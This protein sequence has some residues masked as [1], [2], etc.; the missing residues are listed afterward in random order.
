MSRL[1]IWMIATGWALLAGAAGSAQAQA[2]W[3]TRPIVYVVP[4]AVGGNTDTLARL[5]S[6]KLAASLGQPIVIENK[7]GAGGNIGSD[8]VAKAKPDGYTILGGTISSHAINA[9]VYPN[10]PYDPVKSFE[11]VILLGSNPL[12]FAVNASTPYKSLKEVLDAAK[13]KPGELAFASPGPGTSPHL[14]GELLKTLTRVD[15]THVPYKGSGPALSDVIGGQVPI[16]IDTTIVLGA[17]IKAGKL[18]PLAV[19]YPKRLGTLPDVPTAAEAGVPGWEVVSWQAVFA[20]AGTPKP[21]VQRLNTEI[22]RTMKM[23]DVQARLVDLGVEVG[24]GPPE[25]LAEFQ[26]AEIAKWATVVKTAGV[27]PE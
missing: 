21:I 11:P 4:F 15:L 2:E 10:M 20:P 13:T 1:N 5:L 6:Q 23:P 9:S 19:A 8:F 18:R 7:P 24:G 22:A 14:A 25:Q 17:Q 27:K 12:V 3:P 16:I 26:K